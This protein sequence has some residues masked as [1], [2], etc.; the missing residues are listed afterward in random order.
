[1]TLCFQ[2]GRFQARASFRPFMTD[3]GSR[4][5][6][7][8]VSVRSDT[9]GQYTFFAADNRELLLKVLDGCAN[10]GNYWVFVA[11]TTNV[12]VLLEVTDLETGAVRNYFNGLGEVFDPQLDTGAFPC[13][14]GSGQG[15]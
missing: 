1:N 14:D 7:S 11:G 3:P 8:T 2:D 13:G 4:T 9:A 12:E 5:P 15:F 6:A 10:N